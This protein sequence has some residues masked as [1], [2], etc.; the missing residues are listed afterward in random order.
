[1]NRIIN[2]VIYYFEKIY[3]ISTSHKQYEAIVWRD[4]KKHF[5]GSEWKYGVFE[6]EMRIE[7]VFEIA[8][9][10]GATFHYVL[11]EGKYHCRVKVLD[12]FA[13]ELTTDCFVLS[14]HFNN[15]LRDGVVVVNVQSK[16]VE[17]HVKND[18]I[19]NLIYPGELHQQLL[20]HFH[21]SKEIYWAFNKLINENEEPALIIADLMVKNKMNSE[22]N[23]QNK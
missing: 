11:Y 4:L 20:R 10:M 21:T 9:E 19:V 17:Y 16:Y 5:K 8:H 22:E 2:N 13:D 14:A 15:I 23:D 12:D 3:R 6:N 7:S 18:L 1:M